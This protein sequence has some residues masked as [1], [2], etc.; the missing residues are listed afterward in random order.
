[1]GLAALGT[2]F[3]PRWGLLLA[4]AGGIYLGLAGLRHVTKPGKGAEESVATWTH[5]LVFVMVA[6]GVIA[7]VVG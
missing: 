4:I 6:L 5:L 2:L 3:V 1:M 7:T